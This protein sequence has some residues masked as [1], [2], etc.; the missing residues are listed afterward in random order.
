MQNIQQTNASND[1]VYNLR[2]IKQT[3]NKPF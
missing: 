1:T 3:C 2:N